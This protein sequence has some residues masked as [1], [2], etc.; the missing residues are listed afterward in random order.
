MQKSILDINVSCFANYETPG[1]PRTVNLLQWLTSDKY[2]SK[3]EQ[4]RLLNDKAERDKIKATLPAITPSGIFTYRKE[5]NLLKHSGF[6]QFDIDLKGN[7]AIENYAELKKQLCNIK[8]VSYCGLSVSGR[9]YWGLMPI[10]YPEKHKEHFKAIEMAFKS[11][12]IKIDAAPQNVAS[13]RGYSYDPDGYFN[14]N[15]EILKSVFVENQ[16]AK[17]LPQQ[18]KYSGANCNDTRA[19]VERYINEI[20][21]RGIDITEVYKQWSIIGYALISEFGE[22]GRQYFHD[23][24]GNYSNYNYSEAN[25][26]FTE[27][28]RYNGKHEG[29]RVNIGTFFHLCK[30]HG[31]TI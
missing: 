23:I 6:I 19:W 7:E 14:H 21:S 13:L 4:I 25:N 8:N 3:V 18:T 5:E 11:I 27:L 15:A 1:N 2:K 28:L 17:S 29:K 10:A 16:T 31:I 30:Q 24:S 22:A 20:T 12:G 9:G 26:K